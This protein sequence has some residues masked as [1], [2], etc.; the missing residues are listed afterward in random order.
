MAKKQYNHRDRYFLKAKEEGYH[1]RSVYKLEE[2]QKRFPLLRRGA[3]V[4]DLGAYP[5]SFAQFTRKIIGEQAPLFLVDL[6]PVDI[7]HA[8]TRV[9]QGDIFEEDWLTALQHD[10]L[11]PGALD[12]V[13]SDLAPRTSGI[14]DLDH[15]R[16]V[17]LCER[18]LEVGDLLLR[19]GGNILMKIFVGSDYDVFFA[20]V[21]KRYMKVKP[22]KPD[23]T[24]A[25]SKEV[26]IVGLGKRG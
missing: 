18:V 9:W 8:R 14:K 11:F 19:P 21:K 2:I 4:L 16:S 26:F 3:A 25:T 23:A 22:V 1:A 10:P 13:V 5:G 17:E 12:V 6:Q 15:G 24:R 20:E 7:V